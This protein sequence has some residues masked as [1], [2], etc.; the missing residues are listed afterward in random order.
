M[1]RIIRVFPRKTN[2]TPDDDLVR[3]NC[4]PTLFDEADEVHVSV[5]FS[6][7]LERAESLARAWN[8][9]A[10]VSIGGPA[11]GMIGGEF[12][13]GMYVKKGY[14]IHH[15]GCPNSCWF[16]IE[17]KS[18]LTLL[19]IHDGWN[20]LSSN[21]LAC[22]PD[23]I[24]QVFAAL[25]RGKKTFG[26]APQFTG[27]LEAKRLEWWHVEALRDLK[28]KQMFFA[29]DTPD[30]YPWLY[31]AGWA[32]IAGGFTTRS[33]SLRCYVLCGYPKDTFEA[34]EERMRQTVECG[35]MP[36]AMLYRDQQGNRDPEWMR[37]QRS[38]ARPAIIA[39]KEIGLTNSQA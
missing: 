31:A 24:R 16:C 12:V 3:I 19:D 32:L 22:P 20:D 11:T 39:A 36:M 8:P 33:H 29:Y 34:A 21:L 27:G 25:K 6:W 4:A 10:P 5:L 28:P 14:T 7:D 13:P 38:W 9:V 17:S 37:W 1:K 18:E 26:L 35:F 2:A 30:D 15:R 23:H